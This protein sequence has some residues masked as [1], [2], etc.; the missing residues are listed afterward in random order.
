M[1]PSSDIAIFLSVLGITIYAGFKGDALTGLFEEVS[2]VCSC[3]R[4]LHNHI[5]TPRDTINLS[6]GREAMAVG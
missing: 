3:L 1:E 6:T 5:Q 4:K 2:L